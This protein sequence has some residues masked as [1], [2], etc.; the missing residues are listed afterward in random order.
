MCVYQAA[1]LIWVWVLVYLDSDRVR[2]MGHF[3]PK[4]WMINLWVKRE[5][6]IDAASGLFMGRLRV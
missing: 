1:A 5:Y 2:V 6:C 3:N 4:K